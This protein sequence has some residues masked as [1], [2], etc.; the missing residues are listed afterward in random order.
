MEASSSHATRTLRVTSSPLGM[1]D[2]VAQLLCL[3]VSGQQDERR[4]AEQDLRQME[5]QDGF[6]AHLMTLGSSGD[7]DP[8]TRWLAVMYLKNQVARFWQR[9]TGVPYEIG[10]E[11]KATI[12]NG[13]L[14]L[15]LDA[16]DKISTQAALVVARIVRFDFPRVWPD[17]MPMIAQAVEQNMPSQPLG[18]NAQG[19]KV[20][21][22]LH[23][24]LKGLRYPNVASTRLHSNGKLALCA[25][26]LVLPSLV[27][28]T[29]VCTRPLSRS[30]SVLFS[31]ALTLCGDGSTKRLLQ[32]RK[33]FFQVAP[34][35]LPLIMQ[36]L[37]IHHDALSPSLTQA[38]AHEQGVCALLSAIPS[39]VCQHIPAPLPHQ[40]PHRTHTHSS[41][42]PPSASRTPCHASNE[43][44]RLYTH[45]GS[46]IGEWGGG[47]GGGG[48]GGVSRGLGPGNQGAAA[49]SRHRLCAPPHPSFRLALNLD[50]SPSLLS[51]HVATRRACVPVCSRARP[52]ACFA[53][54][55]QSWPR[56]T[57]SVGRGAQ[58]Q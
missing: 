29:R 54:L 43:S 13:C 20:T 3:A 45:A 38:A 4:G 39:S 16:D 27:S 5:T 32:D 51:H 18:D 25:R 46:G 30:L 34:A 6:T 50:V 23:F 47:G 15:S 49:H 41:V 26:E 19:V 57:G 8:Q 10:A 35:F 28:Y 14:P 44:A 21:R 24:C 12:R 1:G 7:L 42:P 33:A 53:Q 22:V 48:G 58:G 31:L 17:I 2:R 55:G 9:R 11:E 36:F 52:C 56:G 37:S 40:L